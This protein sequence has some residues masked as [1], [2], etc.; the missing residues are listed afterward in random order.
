MNSSVHHF[1]ELLNRNFQSS[2]LGKVRAAV[3]DPDGL[4]CQW[5]LVQESVRE[6]ERRRKL[7]ERTR[8]GGENS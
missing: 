2:M 4:R 5:D 1:A 6:T 3:L 8:C 7:E